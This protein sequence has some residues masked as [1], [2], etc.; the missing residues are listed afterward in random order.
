MNRRINEKLWNEEL[1][2][3]CSR[4]FD[5][6]DGTPGAF[7]TKLAPLN[8]YPLISGAANKEQARRMLQIMT[9]PEQFWGEWIMPT[10]SRKEPEY[11]R[12]R[13]W[14][15]NIWGPETY[16]TWLG[17]KRYAS[18]E[19]K[20]EYAQKCVH[21]FMNNWLGAGYC[22]ENYFTLNGRVCSNP[23]YTWGALLCLVGIESVVDLADDGRIVKGPG[24]NESVRMENII[25]DGKPHS[26]SVDYGKPKVA[27]KEQK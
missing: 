3:Y 22:G 11:H 8:F 19:L 4:F 18:G 9:D 2:I 26:V 25:L 21:L 12:Q 5:N 20:A 15:G 24:Y 14:S 10:L 1:G 7:L 13:Y 27:V 17:V 16:L 23:N 6:E